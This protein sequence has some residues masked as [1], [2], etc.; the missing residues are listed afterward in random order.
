M[1]KND[2]ILTGYCFLSALTEN[3]NDLYNNVYIPICKRALSLYSLQNKTHG[4]AIDIKKIIADEYGIDVPSFVVKKLINSLFKS[5]SNR[6]KKL[7]K[8]NVFQNGETFEIQKFAFSDLEIE[9]KKGQRNAKALQE[10]FE[11]FL[12]HA[13]GIENCADYMTFERNSNI[14]NC[15]LIFI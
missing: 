5:F 2:N 8:F 12:I 14:V 15:I 13:S 7:Y 11:K 6:T 9:Y 1:N 10:A 3:Q 4:S